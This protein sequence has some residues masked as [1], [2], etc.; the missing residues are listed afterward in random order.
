MMC[1]IL[2]YDDNILTEKICLPIFTYWDKT[3]GGIGDHWGRGD[4]WNMTL[5]DCK[6]YCKENLNCNAITFGEMA[7]PDGARLVHKACNIWKCPQP[8][9]RPTFFDFDKTESG[10]RISYYNFGKTLMFL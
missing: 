8:L 1:R 2:L 3:H 9:P 10:K 5:E 4:K 7:E 6:T